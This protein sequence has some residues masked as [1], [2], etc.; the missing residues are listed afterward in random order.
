MNEQLRVEFKV[1]V[2]RRPEPKPV[3]GAKQERQR[4]DRA[5]RRARNLAL[6]YWIDSLIR[7]GEVAHLAA[8]ARMCGDS[9][10]R[11]S[12]TM[13]MM[14]TSRA[15]RERWLLTPHAPSPNRAA[16]AALDSALAC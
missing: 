4:L 1:A 13:R 6:A 10:A 2:A 14:G 7:S 9:R 5:A 3:P 16:G 12:C 11:I 15:Q 8:V